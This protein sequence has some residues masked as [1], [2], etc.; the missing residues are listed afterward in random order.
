MKVLSA[1]RTALIRFKTNINLYVFTRPSSVYSSEEVRHDFI[2]FFKVNYGHTYIPS[3]KIFSSTD[4]TL[5]FVN[6]GMNQFKPVLLGNT[7]FHGDYGV[8]RR[9]VNSQRCIRVGGK[10]NDLDIVGSDCYHHTFFEMLG[11]WSFGDYFKKEACAMAWE[12][13]TKKYRLPVDN[14]Y[15]TY[16]GGS[17]EMNLEPDLETKDIWLSLG[18]AK[19]RIFSFGPKD[20]FWEMG[21]FGPCGPSTEIHYDQIGNRYVPEAVNVDGSNVIEIWNLVFTQYNKLGPNHLEKLEKLHVDTGMGLER[22]TAILQGKL[23]NYDTD[24][25]QPIIAKLEDMSNCRPYCGNVGSKDQDKV[26]AAY[27]IISDHIRMLTIAIADGIIPGPKKR[28]LILRRILRRAVTV[29]TECLHLSPMFMGKL[30]PIVVEKLKNIHPELTEKQSYVVNIIDEAEK[31]YYNLLEKGDATVE[32]VV[33]KL[34]STEKLFPTEMAVHLLHFLGYP[35]ERF[36]AKLDNY[37]KTFD[38]SK[39]NQ[40]FLVKNAILP[41]KEEKIIQQQFDSVHMQTLSSLK[42]RKTEQVLQPRYLVTD[43]G[44]VFTPISVEVI[45]VL[46]EHGKA[47]EDYMT[48][49]SAVYLLLDK[50]CFFHPRG[51]SLPHVGEIRFPDGNVC[52]VNKVINVQ[53][54]VLHE[55]SCSNNALPSILSGYRAYLCASADHWLP[56]LRAYDGA[57]MITKVLKNITPDNVIQKTKYEADKFVMELSGCISFADS[58]EIEAT[59]NRCICNEEDIETNQLHNQSE[60]MRL[61]PKDVISFTIIKHRQQGKSCTILHCITGFRAKR[62][63]EVAADLQLAIDDITMQFNEIANKSMDD[64]NVL[65][66]QVG[67]LTLKLTQSEINAVAKAELKKHLL[68]LSGKLNTLRRKMKKKQ[69]V[70]SVSD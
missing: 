30:V 29:G 3:S 32:R 49:A 44:L 7:D 54:W 48:G 51:R 37:G 15:I 27:R 66:E 39:I 68:T 63:K 22:I 47:V 19:D 17:K 10:H 21:D 41:M 11:S 35:R 24:L 46:D 53:N 33:S 18:V 9:A 60:S 40:Y 57:T 26:D 65:R 2:N 8:V 55:V 6:A 16:F 36:C 5:M 23:S 25:F 45:A 43:E 12:L 64:L 58:L 59:V 70:Q 62:C 1:V 14:L 20:N 67:S 38:A 61:L 31:E 28:D 4:E 13:L 56:M 52:K 50:S 69:L 42:L 34:A